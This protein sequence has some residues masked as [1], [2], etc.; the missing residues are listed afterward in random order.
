M[1]HAGSVEYSW[2]EQA[3]GIQGNLYEKKLTALNLS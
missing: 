1:P 3:H 2:R